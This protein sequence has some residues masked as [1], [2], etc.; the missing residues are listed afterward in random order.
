[1]YAESDSALLV[2]ARAPEPGR[3]KS[4]LIPALGAEG[5]ALLQRRMTEHTLDTACAA[6][7]GCVSLWCTP[8]VRH[9]FFVACSARYGVTLHEQAGPGLGERLLGAHDWA[10]R[11]YPRLLVIGTDCPILSVQHL[12]HADAELRR[13]DAVVIPAEDGGYVLLGLAR[14][15]PEVFREIDWGSSAVL[16]QTL[17]RLRESER[18]C[19]VLPPLWDVD[20]AADLQRLAA[21]LPGMVEDLPGPAIGP[22]S[23]HAS[24]K[25]SDV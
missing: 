6:R 13:S 4:R 21:W 15:C 11:A 7:I 18:S 16:D 17:A 10:F 25:R 2:F 8:C 24:T 9:P 3:T 19:Q 12:R 23:G 1:M 5:A 14:R 22:L 20:R